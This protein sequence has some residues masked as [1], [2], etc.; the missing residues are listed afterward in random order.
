MEYNARIELLR[1]R[2]NLCGYGTSLQASETLQLL[3][4]ECVSAQLYLVDDSQL[5]WREN[6]SEK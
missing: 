2:S 6:I 4:F 3:Y 1:Q 5:Q